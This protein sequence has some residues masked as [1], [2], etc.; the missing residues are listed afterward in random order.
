[1]PGG[2]DKLPAPMGKTRVRKSPPAGA[3]TGRDDEASDWTEDFANHL[4]KGKSEREPN[5]VWSLPAPA[6]IAKAVNGA[7]RRIS[8]FLS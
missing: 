3:A 1:M 2:S 4:G 6:L 5:S 7:S 8:A